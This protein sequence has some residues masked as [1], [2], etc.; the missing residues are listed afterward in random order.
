[1]RKC[2]YGDRRFPKRGYAL[3]LN[4]KA[5]ESLEIS[6]LINYG[7]GDYVLYTREPQY[8]NGREYLGVAQVNTDDTLTPWLKE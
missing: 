6:E 8:F 3:G 5:N 4:F 1:M 7:P 2:G